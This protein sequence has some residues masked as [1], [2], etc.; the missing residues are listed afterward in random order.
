MQLK[1][2]VLS[3]ILAIFFTWFALANSQMV[4][5]SIL[6]RNIQVSLS[7][8]IL[9]SILVGVILTGIISAAE[10]TR[11]FGKIRDIEGKLKHDE[12]L[13]KGEKKEK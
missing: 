9:I 2:L 5:V 11:M 8:V 13:L 1:N 10:Q 3:I 7:L 12:A 4:T 6:I